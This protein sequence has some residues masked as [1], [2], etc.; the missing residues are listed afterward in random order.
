MEF[1]H[2]KKWILSLVGFALCLPACL[3][4]QFSDSFS[5][6]N[7]L[8]WSGDTT[9]FQINSAGELQLNAPAGASGSFIYAPVEFSDSMTWAYR[10][11]L[12]F[13]PSS[14]NQL[15]VYLGLLHPDPGAS[16]GYFLEIGATGDMD[17]ILFKY[18]DGTA[19]EI[20]GQSAAGLVADDPVELDLFIVANQGF[21][22]FYKKLPNQYEFLFSAAY[23]QLSLSQLSFF[24]IECLYSDTRRD[25]FYFDDFLVKPF[26]ADT[27]PPDITAYHIQNDRTLLLELSEAP[28]FSS[29]SILS[30]Y[31]LQPGTLIP[32][33]V[34]VNG[35]SIT[36]AWEEPFV[37]QVPYS[38][39]V[40]ML[41]DTSGNLMPDRVIEFSYIQVEKAEQDEI[42]ITELMVDPSPAIG[43]PQTEYI[44][45]YNNSG[46]VFDLSGYKVRIGSNERA[47]RDSIIFPG[48]YIIVTDDDQVASFSFG[49]VM[50]ISNMPALPNTGGSIAISDDDD[51]L[52]YQI[53]Y[54]TDWYQDDQ[55]NDG[56]WSM[57]MINP[58]W[59]CS[60]GENWAASE[61]L[62]G[63]TPG[64]VNSKWILDP[65]TTGPALL[66]L[67]PGAA[68]MI[69]LR[70]SE[71]IE[72]Y[73]MLEPG[74]FNV[75][76]DLVIVGLEL[77]DQKTLEIYFNKELDEGL[78]YQL[79]PFEALDCLGNP[80]QIADTVLFGNLSVPDAGDIL[81][82]EILFNP[83]S[84]GSRFIEIINTS[85]KF[86]N[87]GDLSIG[88]I[89][90]HMTQLY[91]VGIQEL[92]IPGGI[93]AIASDRSDILKR[94][95]VP[96]PENLY[97]GTLP[98]WD[99][100]I[101]NASI[102]FEGLVIDSLTYSADW[103]HPVISDQEGVSLE[104]ISIFFPGSDE[105]IW[106]SSASLYGFATPTGPNSQTAILAG[107]KAL[108]RLTNRI[109][110]PDDDGFND[111]L[112]VDF[113]P[114]PGNYVA[115]V[116][117]YD[118]DGREIR[119]LLSN[120]TLGASPVVQWDGRNSE[121]K[122]AEMGI[123]ILLV[124]LWDEDGR[125]N[126]Y[127]EP[128]TLIKR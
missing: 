13:A 42:L 24:G 68:N 8:G 23:D 55:K 106:H 122:L 72:P 100:E 78:T 20:I 81:I 96:Y 49:R 93:A 26:E 107:S 48:A 40:T 60:G 75:S 111:F 113:E 9:D 46:K 85:Q 58:M 70:F 66:S 34:Q 109:F 77:K 11:R 116:W 14:S 29:A 1:F 80:R 7:L 117:V 89:N 126:K 18:S 67:F 102:V 125:V 45:L 38:L 103:H 92:L 36:V 99:D 76:P 5:D 21:W 101:D 51:Q 3:Y 108:F 28:E 16:P 6:G 10:F 57:E 74:R 31:V 69:E 41:R 95:A 27:L 112:L 4:A 33:A 97:E 65:D 35:S 84:G 22:K 79:L 37:S 120:E 52:I 124:Q 123:Y 17:A 121:G 2:L 44:E 12:D 82:N 59:L 118:L 25:K 90:G 19:S 119:Q 88:R 30:N 94:F 63:G 43:L 86:I 62:S 15:I 54:T 39:H 104:R 64:S 73:L 61:D 87:I 105:N 91:P 98:S 32:S 110:S 114:G 71:K 50:G 115:S 83:A 128:C 127:Q 53:S 47:L 56:G